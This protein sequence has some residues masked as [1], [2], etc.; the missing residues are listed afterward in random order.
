MLQPPLRHS[1]INFTLCYQT[2]NPG[3]LN[4]C[5]TSWAHEEK[6]SLA[7]FVRHLVN[8]SSII[9]QTKETKQVQYI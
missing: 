8:T 3:I 1:K 4:P 2:L 7:D 5:R 6:R 9:S